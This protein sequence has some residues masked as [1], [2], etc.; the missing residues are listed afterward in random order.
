MTAQLK[1][2]TDYNSLVAFTANK[3]HK[4][5]GNNTTV[6]RWTENDGSIG[7]TIQLHGNT[8]AYITNSYIQVFNGGWESVTTKSRLNQI[9]RDN[10]LGQIW[11]KNYVWF[12]NGERF[13]SGKRFERNVTGEYKD[14]RTP[15]LKAMSEAGACSEGRRIIATFEAQGVR[16]MWLEASWSSREFAIMVIRRKLGYNAFLALAVKHNIHNRDGE[17]GAIYQDNDLPEAF[18]S[19]AVKTYLA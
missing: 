12:L 2:R 7:L 4:I 19:E 3:F 8:I 6:F 5:L 18:L 14:E 16:K 13:E 1:S 17:I 10:G 9:L 11:Q 15:L